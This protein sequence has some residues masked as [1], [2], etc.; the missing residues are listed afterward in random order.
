M[1]YVISLISIV[2]ACAHAISGLLLV[3]SLQGV[4]GDGWR[5]TGSGLR[6]Q[7]RTRATH[8]ASALNDDY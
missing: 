7:I 5:A 1:T 8:P 6:M 3:S 4:G 2:F